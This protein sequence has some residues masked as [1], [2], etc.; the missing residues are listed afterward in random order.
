M[1]DAITYTEMLK[2]IRTNE[3]VEDT[4]GVLITRP[5]LNTGNSILK[6]LNYFHHLVQIILIFICLVTVLTGAVIDIPT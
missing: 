6:S 3:F 5:D 1:I 4:I 2:H